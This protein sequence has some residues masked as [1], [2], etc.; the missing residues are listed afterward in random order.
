MPEDR[1]PFV[2]QHVP[3]ASLH[4]LLTKSEFAIDLGRQV[5]EL[6]RDG[7]HLQAVTMLK[8][9]IEPPVYTIVSLLPGLSPSH[10]KVVANLTLAL[11]DLRKRHRRMNDLRALLEKWS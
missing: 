1:E 4:D 9:V 7:K 6:Q 11:T 3:P 10:Q 2:H 5:A 8:I